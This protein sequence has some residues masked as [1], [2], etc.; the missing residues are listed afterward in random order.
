MSGLWPGREV[1]KRDDELGPLAPGWEIVATLEGKTKYLDHNRKIATFGRPPTDWASDLKHAHCA[2]T[3]DP[4][5]SI[6]YASV[7]EDQ[8]TEYIRTA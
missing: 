2:D 1:I 4:F 3:G 8:R 6:R 7:W 5:C